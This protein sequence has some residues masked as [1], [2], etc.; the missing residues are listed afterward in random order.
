[1]M[2]LRDYQKEA[3]QAV[4]Q[5]WEA[6]TRATLMVLPTGTG[7]TIVFSSIIEEVV[8]QGGRALVLAHRGE[9]LQQA[10]DKLATAT[11][12]GCA[13][14]KAEENALDT[15]FNVVVG[16]VQTLQKEKRRNGHNF[17]H[18]IVDE[19][20]H[21]ISPSYRAVL[22]HFPEASILGVTATAD[23]GDKRDLGEVFET[24]CYEYT[25]PA[26]I[27]AGWLSRIQALTIPLD[28]DLDGVKQSAGDFAAAG[29]ASALDP[30]LHQI[31]EHLVI[32]AGDRKTV[33]FLP[34]VATGKKFRDILL[35]KGVDAREVD[36]ES[37]DRAETLDWFRRADKGAVLCNAMLLTEGWDQ[38]DVDCICVLRA[39]K[40][41][42]LYA[43][44]VGRGARPLP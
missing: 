35:S 27:N 13:V 6:G 43:Q 41:R 10:A 28:I 18:I 40:I 4:L 24:L 44:M 29:V 36:G 20:H 9:L 3:K 11:G 25:L 5:A 32:E 26:A 15:W 42:S 23:R 38:P 39:T 30:Y 21:A 8:R 19:A 14:E 22:D 2:T 16:S 12:L 33:V 34:L 7:K 1:M 17:T 31:A 37:R